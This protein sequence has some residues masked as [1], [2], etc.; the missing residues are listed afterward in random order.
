[1]PSCVILILVILLNMTVAQNRWQ[2]SS[3]Q[4]TTI[5]SPQRT[6]IRNPQDPKMF[7]LQTAQNLLN[8]AQYFF[9]LPRSCN[10]QGNNYQCGS[11]LSC[12][13][14]GKKP[15][16]SCNGG[17]FWSCCV[18]NN[19]EPSRVGLVD[20]PEC[21]KIYVR[22]SKI[23]GG[24]NAKFGQ[25]PWQ[26]AIVKQSLLSRKI[27]C[28]GALINKKW[29]VTA[30]H[31]VY[32]SHTSNLKVRLGEHNIRQ[33]TESLP[34]EEYPVRRKVVNPGYHPS[35]YRHDIALLELSH[36]VV[37]RKHI[38]PACLPE[39]GDEFAGQKATV[40][41]W[42]RI[43]YGNRN[44]PS[45]LQKVEVNVY[46]LK[47]CQDMYKLVGRRETI[48]STMLCAGYKAGGKDSCQG[49][50]GGPLVTKKDNR[51]VLI[52]LVSWGVGCARANLPGIYT[53]I[54][55]YVDWI[56]RYIG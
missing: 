8:I 55:E 1:M 45:E 20:D 10:Y 15:V 30:A 28:G 32:R 24:S 36:P 25:Q 34:H 12:W 47:E 33:T 3:P 22:N 2:W 5:S 21:G 19:A 16:D 48:Y 18:P 50:S 14:Q 11:S 26:V 7:D 31:C 40:T 29:V 41:G 51:A 52:G 6:S 9:T 44:A 17:M 49:D 42:G 38:I 13:I 46:S 56:R 54:S 4:R 23:V 53:R 35:T 43:Q 39:R 37:Y 27:A